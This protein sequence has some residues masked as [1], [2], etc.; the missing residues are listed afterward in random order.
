VSVDGAAAQL[1]HMVRTQLESR[2]IRDRRV[3]AA[4]RAVDRARFVPADRRA[5]A[6]ADHPVPIGAG[7]TISQP[8]M[9]G[10]MTERLELTGA[11]RVLE[12]GTGSGYQTAILARLAA[13]VYTM[14]IHGSLVEEA[15]AALG[16]LGDMNIH[17][18]TGNG[19]RGWPEAAPFDRILCAAAA[20]D[21][22]EVWVEQLA[23]PGILI[24]PV[25]GAWGQILARL[26]RRGGR[27]ERSEFCP[28]RF[29]PLVGED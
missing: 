17:F 27:V 4:M 18:R 6:Y 1:D 24:T 2:D 22:P 20:S 26:E 3:L 10:L 9:V 12:I 23:D 25:G 16:A 14:E 15:R 13:E 5:D 7:Q 19:R 21:V 11:E 29:V 8:Y 28:C